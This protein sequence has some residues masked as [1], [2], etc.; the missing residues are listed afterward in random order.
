MLTSTEAVNIENWLSL[1]ICLKS[2]VGVTRSGMF[3]TTFLIRSQNQ[4]HSG[5]VGPW[6]RSFLLETVSCL[7]RGCF[8]CLLTKSWLALY[9]PMDCSTPGSSVHGISQA[10]IL[11]WVAISFSRGSSPS[12]DRTHVSCIVG[13]MLHHWA[14]WEAHHC[15]YLFSKCSFQSTA[16]PPSTTSSQN[17]STLNFNFTCR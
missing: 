5:R 15:K 1:T 16:F 2:T 8:C 6:A 13:R 10:R 9:S 7:L 17:S 14:I 4:A 11:E 3:S 12:T